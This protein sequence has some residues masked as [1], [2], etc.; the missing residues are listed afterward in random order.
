MRASCEAGRSVSPCSSTQSANLTTTAAQGGDS[1]PS[2][3][4]KLKVAQRQLDEAKAQR[5]RQ[6]PAPRRLI[7]PRELQRLEAVLRLNLEDLSAYLRMKPD[8]ARNTLRTLLS[9]RITFEAPREDARGRCWGF[10][11]TIDA[12]VLLSGEVRAK[13]S[14]TRAG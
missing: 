1:I 2:L 10:S 8:L 6:R 13:V 7:S 9:E 3:V 14:A 12:S 11:G 4:A 5:R